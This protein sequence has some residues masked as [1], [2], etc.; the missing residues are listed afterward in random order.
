MRIF[1]TLLDLVG[2]AL[3]VYAVFLFSFILGV[4]AAGVALLI[5]SWRL[6]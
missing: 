5:L 2:M 6:A 4:A 1:T 3:L